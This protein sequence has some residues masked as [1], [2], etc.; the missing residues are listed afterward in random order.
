MNETGGYKYSYIASVEL[1]ETGIHVLT[2]KY[3]IQPPTSNIPIKWYHKNS[4]ECKTM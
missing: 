3:T 1:S 4:T 2:Y